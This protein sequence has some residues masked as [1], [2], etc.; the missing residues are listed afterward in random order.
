MI[1]HT[2]KEKQKTQVYAVEHFTRVN[3]TYDTEDIEWHEE[4]KSWDSVV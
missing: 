4:A 1:L 3:S 2:E